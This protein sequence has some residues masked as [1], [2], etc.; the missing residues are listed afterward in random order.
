MCILRHHWEVIE[1]SFWITFSRP[2]YLWLFDDCAAGS[3]MPGAS[4]PFASMSVIYLKR[5]NDRGR[6]L[7]HPLRYRQGLCKERGSGGQ[8]PL[9][10][11]NYREL[12]RALAADGPANRVVSNAKL[13]GRLG[14][15]NGGTKIPRCCCSRPR[16]RYRQ[17]HQT[18]NC[19]CGDCPALSSAQH[20]SSE[21]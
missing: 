5:K 8:A 20:M 17:L 10:F 12:S 7:A 18:S 4:N 1:V 15:T 9:R 3:V 14:S 6:L 11:F 19:L 21:S 16:R 2:S 13:G